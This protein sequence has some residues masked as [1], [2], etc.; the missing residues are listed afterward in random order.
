MA[1][2]PI[3]AAGPIA[4]TG[5]DGQV[6]RALRGYLAGFPNQVWAL[7]RGDDWAAACQDAEVIVHLAGTLRPRRPDTDEAANSGT[8]RRMMAAI[9][10]SS[11][12]R[13]V[14]LS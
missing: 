6:G 4:I 5:A 11:V 1:W 14:F 3:A 7:G 10:G 13:V 2:L 8:V 9:D 12:Q